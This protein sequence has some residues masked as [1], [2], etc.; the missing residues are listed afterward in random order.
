VN[1]VGQL[2]STKR[3]RPCPFHIRT[4]FKFAKLIVLYLAKRTN[5]IG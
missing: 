4:L 2:N 5:Q 1:C 3:L